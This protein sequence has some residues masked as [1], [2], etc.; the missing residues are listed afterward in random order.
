MK[1]ARIEVNGDVIYARYHEGKYYPLIGDLFGAYTF[2]A[3]LDESVIKRVMAPVE[4]PNIIA[5][6]LNY[7][8]HAIESNMK[9]PERPVLFLK[10]TTSVVGP[11]DAIVL[12][13]TAPHEVDYEAELVVVIGRT[14]K[15]VSEDEALEYVLGYAIGNDVSARDCQ[16]RLDSQ[17]ARGKSFDTFCPLGPWIETELEADSL[18]IKAR[19]NGRTV[20]DSFTSD[21]IFNV[22]QLVS[23]CSHNMTLLPGTVI[24]TGTPQG[25]GFARK[26]PLFLSAGDIIEV[27]IDGIGV[28]R[29]TVVNE[30]K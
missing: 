8:Q 20:Q 3:A 12:P 29:N 14:A 30:N 5:V 25:V 10:T 18:A 24:L 27:E 2:A 23:Y 4:P 15:N 1:I 13:A 26:P 17:W 11:D 28:L 9:I 7:R 6:G 22:R 21:M 16:L 19:L